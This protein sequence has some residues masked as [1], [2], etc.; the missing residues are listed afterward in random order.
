MKIKHGK[1]DTLPLCDA[2]LGRGAGQKEAG[3]G[4]VPP[5]QDPGTTCGR[6]VNLEAHSHCDPVRVLG[7]KLPTSDT[8]CEDH[9]IH[10]FGKY[11]FSMH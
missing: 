7:P 4:P 9:L 5:A 8:R 10:A 11:L 1:A 6:Q 2:G 3:W